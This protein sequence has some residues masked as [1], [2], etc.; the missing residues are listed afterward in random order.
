MVLLRKGIL[1]I[2]KELS[3]L[4]QAWKTLKVNLGQKHITD[5]EDFIG[6]N[7]IVL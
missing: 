2:E 6:I 7:Q 3:C 5:P 4:P 1:W